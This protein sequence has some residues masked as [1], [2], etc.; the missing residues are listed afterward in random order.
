[1]AALAG[2]RVIDA[3]SFLTGPFA[4]M[5]LADMGADVVKVEPPAGEGFRRFGKRHNGVS[6][7]FINANRNKR[8]VAIDLQ[9]AEGRAQFD[10][11]LDDADVLFTNWRPKTT[12]SLGLD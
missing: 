7:S 11:L 10:R 1:M 12:A 8:S 5:M 3:S 2:I 9:D 6:I 4:A